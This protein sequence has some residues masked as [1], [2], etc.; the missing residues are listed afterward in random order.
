MRN[1]FR[2]IPDYPDYI[3]S[4]QG[5]VRSLARID[6]KGAKRKSRV[7]KSHLRKD[8]YWGIRLVNDIA[9]S[10]LL[11]HR[12]LARAWI[13]NRLD[14]P[15]VDHINGNTS[16]NNLSNL[17]WVRGLDNQRK[18]MKIVGAVPYKG[19]TKQGNKYSARIRVD[20]TGHYLGTFETAEEAGLAYDCA[21]DR[22]F[23]EFS[24]RNYGATK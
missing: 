1:E 17:Q 11:L 14:L 3:I 22:Y 10:S 5:E 23:G 15:C 4:A 20:G 12:L 6:R 2:P 8:N 13:E 21:A 9:Q 7:I 18:A 16:D 24:Y 19:V